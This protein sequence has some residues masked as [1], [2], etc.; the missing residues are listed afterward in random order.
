MGTA[1]TCTTLSGNSINLIDEDN[2]RRILLRL[3]EEVTDTRRTN[4]DEHLY[5]IRTGDAEEGNTCFT[6]NCLCKQSLTGSRRTDKKH[7]LRDTRTDI[8]ILAGVL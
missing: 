2:T 6:G 1:E 8:G 7:S 4:T 5:E 3:T